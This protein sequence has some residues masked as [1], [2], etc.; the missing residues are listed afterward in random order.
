MSRKSVE[1]A[2]TWK[3]AWEV[4]RATHRLLDPSEFNRLRKQ[5]T[6]RA[7]VKQWLQDNTT[8]SSNTRNV[9]FVRDANGFCEEHVVHWRTDTLRTMFLRCKLAAIESIGQVFEFSYFYRL[10]PEYVDK[11]KKQEGLCPKHYTGTS[12]SARSGG[13]RSPLP[14]SVPHFHPGCT[15][16]TNSCIQDFRC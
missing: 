16:V 2:Q 5:E 7:F 6:L 13:G 4:T 9:V 8:P 3:R 11:R 10:I 14:F 15:Q 12:E 1:A